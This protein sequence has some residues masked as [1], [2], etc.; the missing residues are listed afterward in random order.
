MIK[1]A[2]QPQS[3][4]QR[5]LTL[6]GL[7]VW[8]IL[9]AVV[10][11]IGAKIVPTVTEY[12]GCLKGVKLAANENSPDAARTAF[13][14]YAEVGYITAITGNDLNITQGREGR[15][16]VSFDYNKEISLAGPVYLLI[17]YHGSSNIGQYNE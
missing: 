10:V 13:D 9:I 14:R 16:K 1:T 15:L 12:M 2:R 8:A 4:K 11:I 7:L 17:K 5:G 6:M 3:V